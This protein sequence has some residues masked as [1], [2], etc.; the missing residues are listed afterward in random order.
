VG[1]CTSLDSLHSFAF[2]QR[3]RLYGF[4]RNLR[5]LTKEVS[6]DLIGGKRYLENLSTE[7]TCLVCYLPSSFRI[8][9]IA[10]AKR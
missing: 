4:Y 2:F 8:S 9:D 1:L 6:Y 5:D 10:N 7:Q 3:Q